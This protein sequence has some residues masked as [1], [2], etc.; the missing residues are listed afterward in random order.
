V[1]FYNDDDINCDYDCV[2]GVKIVGD[3]S[4]RYCNISESI[5]QSV[6][7]RKRRSAYYQGAAS[8][9]D[10]SELS[11]RVEAALCCVSPE[12]KILCET[13]HLAC[14]FVANDWTWLAQSLSQLLSIGQT[15]KKNNPIFFSVEK[16]NGCDNT[17]TQP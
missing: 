11:W 14:K 12:P 7:H 9:L 3:A 5:S 17:D 4:S 13:L 6:C 8:L 1:G 2:R 16:F 10:V 15:R